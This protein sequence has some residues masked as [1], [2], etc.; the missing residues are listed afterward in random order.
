MEFTNAEKDRINQLYGNDFADITPDDALLIA[1]WE[2]Y[3]A[4]TN[5][6]LQ[7]KIDAIKDETAERKEQARKVA[8]KAKRNLTELKNAA[9]KRLEHIENE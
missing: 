2:Q 6:E 5:A 1:K 8:D 3:K 7:A 9:M 4:E